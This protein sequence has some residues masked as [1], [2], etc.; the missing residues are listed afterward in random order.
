MRSK[1]IQKALTFDDVLLVPAKSNLLP[2]ETSYK[3]KLTDEIE[4]NIPILSAAMDTVTTSNLA[5][6]LANE[7]GIGIIH[8][9]MSPQEQAKE[10]AKV[11]K[12]ESG[13]VVNPITLTSDQPVSDAIKIM[14][15]ENISG[16]PITDKNNE[17]VG[18]LTNRD[19]R[20]NKLEK[21]STVADLMTNNLIVGSPSTTREEAERKMS[22]NRIEKLPLVDEN[23]KLVGLITLT[24]IAKRNNNPRACVDSEGRLRAGAS[25]GVGEGT[26]ERV[27]LLVEAGLDILVIDTAHGHNVSVSKRVSEV[28]SLYPKLAIIAG[29]VVT[30]EATKDL[31]LAG[32]NVVKV[33]VGP[34]S[35]C[36]TRIVAGVGVPQ[37]TAVMDCA[38]EAE[39]YGGTII[40]DGGI[41]FSGD[42]AKALAGGA[43]CVML[44]SLFAGTE[45]APGEKILS[46]GRTFKSYR[47]M[48]SIEAM[49]KGS[50]DRY[51]QDSDDEKQLIPEGIE[52]R[53]PFK[54]LLKD[55]VH[56]LVG[57]LGQTMF[58]TGCRTIDELRRN[59]QFVEITSASL[60]ESHPHDVTI[61][62][63][64]PNYHKD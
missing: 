39:K 49:K 5:I 43:H 30:K 55:T 28:R 22:E 38:T 11:K 41:K 58:Y 45:E 17:L 33:G 54:G 48:G 12:W 3:T 25:V 8:K 26:L 34:G 24:D 36:T 44:G 46:E 4:L 47:G 59:A 56:Q 13:V 16:F 63:E 21:N 29:N 50:K 27:K 61:T 37:L 14:K 62:K 32:A 53:I 6:S 18:I 15:I 1:I 52:G 2:K 40:A 10:V 23:N 42:I 19:L 35:I 57:G 60:K 7:G 51:F 9:N 20:C 31:L 64:A